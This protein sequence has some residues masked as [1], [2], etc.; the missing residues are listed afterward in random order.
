[1]LCHECL[2]NGKARSAV[3]LCKF[4][5][6]G[7]CKQHMIELYTQQ[8][9]VP[10]YSCRHNPAGL[11]SRPIEAEMGSDKSLPGKDLS[12]D[13]VEVELVGARR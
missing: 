4:C 5:F 6:V 13:A 8:V 9:T 7:L 2:M 12:A 1:M 3:A 10:Q 11:P